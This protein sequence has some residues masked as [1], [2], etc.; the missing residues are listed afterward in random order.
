MKI[1]MYVLLIAPMTLFARSEFYE[2]G[3]ESAR[4]ELN[5]IREILDNKI[6]VTSKMISIMEDYFD[7]ENP[8]HRRHYQFYKGRLYHLNVVS[9]L[10]DDNL[11]FEYA[12]EE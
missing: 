6:E 8:L 9:W 5:D 7:L 10:M 11:V 2:K 1:L 12:S 3:I 4:R